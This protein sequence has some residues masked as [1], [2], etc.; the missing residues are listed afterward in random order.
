MGMDP[1]TIVAIASLAVG[2]A[3]YVEQKNSAEDAQAAQQKAQSVQKGVQAAQAATERRNQIREERVRRAR[4]MQASQNTGTVS[5]S[6]E[7][8]AIG[9]LSTQLGTN[10]GTNLA[11]KAA[12]QEISLY[13]Q[14]ASDAMFSAQQAGQLFSLA[15]SVFGAT[16]G[17]AVS[18]M[19]GGSS[20]FNPTPSQISFVMKE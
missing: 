13:N 17:K 11:M 15:G 6:G 8:G 12:G 14:Q 19:T 18:G 7:M 2:T 1:I 9:G 3:S 20:A 10:I 16:A 4:L 5:S